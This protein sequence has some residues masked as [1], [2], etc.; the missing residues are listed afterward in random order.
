MDAITKATR[1]EGF[2]DALIFRQDR[3]KQVLA[4]L[5]VRE[6]TVDEITD[7]LVELGI[8]PHYN[9]N[10]VAPRLTELKEMGVV[11]TCGTRKAKYSNKNIAVWR[12]V[13]LP[14]LFGEPMPSPVY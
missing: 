6:L 10:Y 13:E 7:E 2:N 4:V 9:R 8:I 3:A 14:N 5:G 1:K 12:R 11:E